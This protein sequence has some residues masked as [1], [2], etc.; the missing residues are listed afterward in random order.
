MTSR[1]HRR[2]I[3]GCFLFVVF[4]TPAI[5]W[6]QSV[7]ELNQAGVEAFSTGN[8]EEAAQKFQAAYAIEPTPSVKKNEALA[9]FKAQKCVQAR[10]AASEYLALPQTEELSVKESQTII[11][12]CT[13]LDAESKIAAGGLDEASALLTD[14]KSKNPS[15]EDTAKIAELE[16][17][18]AQ[19]KSELAEQE[20]A[21]QAADAEAAR[22]RAAAQQAQQDEQKDRRMR[23]VGLSI[24]STGAAI[25]VGTL[26]YHLALATGTS[27]K[28]KD[29]AETG[30]RATYD[31]LGKRLE[32]G[33]W[34]APVLYTVGA[35]TAGVGGFLWYRAGGM[36]GG[37]A[38][39][40]KATEAGVSLT[41]RF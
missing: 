32:T 17:Q 25:L 8:F 5:G 26:V 21:R 41:F 16:G 7:N 35:A 22:K 14:A 19:K 18:I 4:M 9:W 39:N 28:F 34:L 37:G 10:Q 31:K 12:R 23:M 33:N 30:D 6:A 1:T 13:I 24:A 36:S 3:L 15:E 38:E 20:K 2:R 27:S 40:P 29:A 11:V